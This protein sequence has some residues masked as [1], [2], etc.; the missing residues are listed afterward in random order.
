MAE[1]AGSGDATALP[2]AERET[3]RD[4]FL[5]GPL[6][7]CSL[8]LVAMRCFSGK[9][10]D[11]YV[12]TGIEPRDGFLQRTCRLSLGSGMQV[13][14]IKAMIFS[15]QR[16]PTF[17]NVSSFHLMLTSQEGN[18]VQYSVPKQNGLC[19]SPNPSRYFQWARWC[20]AEHCHGKALSNG[21][22]RLTEDTYVG[23]RHTSK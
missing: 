23:N 21:L 3:L 1:D 16:I 8:A 9:C 12:S 15:D 19:P 22:N 7:R 20:S 18:I 14:I 2:R 10:R 11:G 5:E 17:L 13:I 6:S 4:T